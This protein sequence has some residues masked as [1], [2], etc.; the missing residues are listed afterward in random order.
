MSIQ[1][2]CE[3]LSFTSAENEKNVYFNRKFSQQL[4][5]FSFLDELHFLRF[6]K[7]KSRIVGWDLLEGNLLPDPKLL[8]YQAG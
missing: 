1:F 2:L 3:N 4:K 7:I 6:S 8:V 5:G